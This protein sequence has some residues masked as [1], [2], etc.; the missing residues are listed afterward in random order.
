MINRPASEEIVLASIKHN[1]AR[2]LQVRG[3]TERDLGARVGMEPDEFHHWLDD[4]PKRKETVVKKIATELLVPDFYLFAEGESLV[5]ASSIADFRLSTPARRAY[6]RD[7]L[8]AIDLA[9]SIQ[10]DPLARLAFHSNRRLTEIIPKSWTP[11]EAASKLRAVIGLTDDLQSEIGDARQLYVRLRRWVE[12]FETLV[13][14]FSFSIEDGVGFAVAGNNTFDA[15][16]VNTLGQSYSRRLFTLAHEI[17][18]CILGETGISDPDVLNNAV[19][20]KCNLFAVNFLAPRSLVSSAAQRTITSKQFKI[21]EVRAFA[22]ITKISLYASVLRL[23]ET[24]Y[25]GDRAIA[26]WHAFIKASG[27][28]DFV[29]SGGGG[30]NRQPEWKY[31][32]SRYGSRLAE[33]YDPAIRAGIVDDLDFYRLS[34]IKP[35]YQSDY[36][37]NAPTALLTDEV[38]EPDA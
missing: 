8:K 26:A 37:S 22:K 19:E 27:N 4:P 35:K 32:L 23:V 2:L 28:P 1:V 6:Q 36:F 10:S 5:P 31:K 25:Y 29:K 14:Q 3:L 17:Y 18:H 11:E 16:V 15:I 12:Q 9:K 33:I 20:R 34:G 21:D 38:D 7:T 13:F 30:K 24:G